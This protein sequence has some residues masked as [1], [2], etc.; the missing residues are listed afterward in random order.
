MLRWC[1]AATSRP[2]DSPC[3]TDY[4]SAKQSEYSQ[5]T[6]IHS[7]HTFIE[8]YFTRLSHEN[9]HTYVSIRAFIL[10][11]IGCE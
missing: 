10:S 8:Y 7:T 9:L 2:D 6:S 1:V 4:S 3:V 5:E 11:I